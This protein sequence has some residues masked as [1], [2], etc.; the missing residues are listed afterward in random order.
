MKWTRLFSERLGRGRMVAGLRATMHHR[1]AS[2]M[3]QTIKVLGIDIA[4][5]V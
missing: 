5:V 3:A 4:K 2:P 1:E